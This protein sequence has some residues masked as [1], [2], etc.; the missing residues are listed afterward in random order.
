MWG[1]FQFHV[2]P[3]WLHISARTTQSTAMSSNSWNNVSCI[4][5]WCVTRPTYL[6]QWHLRSWE[7]R[8]SEDRCLNRRGRNSEGGNRGSG[9]GDRLYDH[10]RESY[11]ISLQWRRDWGRSRL[12]GLSEHLRGLG[13]CSVAYWYQLGVWH[14]GNGMEW[15]SK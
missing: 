14:P 9:E 3:C 11:S 8:M 7:G 15:E 12:Q 13:P 2:D 6:L 10:L 4:L 1:R 5:W